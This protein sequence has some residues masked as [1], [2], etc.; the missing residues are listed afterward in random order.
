MVGIESVNLDDLLAGSISFHQ[1][2]LLAGDSEP[3][4]QKTNQGRIGF[5]IYRGGR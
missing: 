5:A 3:G 4:G 2:D 1:V